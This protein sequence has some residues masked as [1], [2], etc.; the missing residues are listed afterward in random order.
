MASSLVPVYDIARYS[1]TATKPAVP[2]RTR[3]KAF[4]ANRATSRLAPTEAAANVA[5]ARGRRLASSSPEEEQ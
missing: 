5:V 1:L 4:A 3:P 2:A